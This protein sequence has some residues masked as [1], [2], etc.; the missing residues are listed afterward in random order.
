[1]GKGDLHTIR[2]PPRGNVFPRGACS[3]PSVDGVR[4]LPLPRRPSPPAGPLPFR[5][6]YRTYPTLTHPEAG[7]LGTHSAGGPLKILVVE[8][9]PTLR[10]GLSDLLEGAG[11]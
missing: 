5:M 11:H 3:I 2:L 6:F 10:N 8:D 1:M 7:S 4:W 9:E